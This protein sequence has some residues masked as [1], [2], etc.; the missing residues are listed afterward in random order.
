MEQQHDGLV[1]LTCDAN[2]LK[3]VNV[4][5]GHAAGDAHICALARMLENRLTPFGKTYRIGG[6]EFAS[7]LYNLTPEKLEEHMQGLLS[8]AQKMQISGFP[9]G[10]AY[11]VTQFDASQDK[12]VQATLKRAD[13]IMYAHKNLIKQTKNK[14]FPQSENA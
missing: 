11:G 1:V 5:G 12:N 8:Q 2:M 10:F 7:L 9:L 3:T 6:D 13:A 4:Q 14:E